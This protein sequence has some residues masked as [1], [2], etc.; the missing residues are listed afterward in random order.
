MNNRLL[1]DYFERKNHHLQSMYKYMYVMLVVANVK[2]FQK[3]FNKLVF[4]NI[5]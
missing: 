4:K 5:C 3:Y 1:D 2:I